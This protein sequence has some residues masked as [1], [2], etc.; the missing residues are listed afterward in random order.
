MGNIATVQA[1]YHAFGRGDVPAIVEHL[2]PEVA[3]EHD[4]VAHGIPWLVPRRGRN[5]VVKFFDALSVVDITRFEPTAFLENETQVF[6]TVHLA[7]TVKTTGKPIRDF[8]GHL[9]TFD[10]NGRVTAFRHFVDTHQHLL[11]SRA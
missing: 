8:E 4:A 11:A 2:H 6:A 1:I 3:W 9:F 10:E 5:E 7:G